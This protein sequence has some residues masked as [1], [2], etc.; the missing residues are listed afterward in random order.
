MKIAD[1]SVEDKS[2]GKLSALQS[3]AGSSKL[4]IKGSVVNCAP[5]SSKTEDLSVNFN[6]ISIKNLTFETSKRQ[7]NKSKSFTKASSR[8]ERSG[9]KS[10]SSNVIGYLNNFL[11]PKDLMNVSTLNRKFF[12]K[13]KNEHAYKLLIS[14]VNKKFTLEDLL[15]ND[16][17]LLA[18]YISRIN[19]SDTN[20]LNVEYVN[21]LVGFILN[22]CLKST[23]FRLKIQKNIMSRGFTYLSMADLSHFVQID[24]STNKIG[25]DG[26]EKLS[27]IIPF[28]EKLE[29]LNVSMN[30]ISSNG[31]NKMFESLKQAKSITELN[32]SGNSLRDLG[33]VVVASFLEVSSTIKIINLSYNAIE[34]KG[35][36]LL[37]EGILKNESLKSIN[38]ASNKFTGASLSHLLKLF[39]KNAIKARGFADKETLG[40]K[41]NFS[42][43]KRT[44]T[45]SEG[46]VGELEQGLSPKLKS[47][48][49]GA[50]MS[51]ASEFVKKLLFQSV[52]QANNSNTT[53]ITNK[54]LS[55]TKLNARQI[56]TLNLSSNKLD[57]ELMNDFLKEISNKELYNNTLNRFSIASTSLKSKNLPALSEVIENNHIKEVTLKGNN[58]SHNTLYIEVFSKA[59]QNSCFLTKLN[60]ENCHIGDEL[61]SSIFKLLSRTLIKEL[62]LNSNELTSES[63]AVLVDS[64][65]D[66]Q[67][68]SLFISSNNF[69][70]DGAQILNKAI[71]SNICS[72]LA[73][74]KISMIDMD[75][76]GVASFLPAIGNSNLVELDISVNNCTDDSG[77]EL[78][79][80]LVKEKNQIENLTVAGNNYTDEILDDLERTLQDKD[81]RLKKL[82]ISENNFTVNGLK[83]VLSACTSNSSLTQLN[84]S[85]KEGKAMSSMKLRKERNPELD[86]LLQE[87]QKQSH[88]KIII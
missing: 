51:T 67:L 43:I 34:D 71:S 14:I 26:I 72:S 69:G 87:Y 82:D 16:G 75:D 10:I 65:N 17:A 4:V 63:L 57:A 15:L 55:S 41:D 19:S 11:D 7:R 21:R 46:I 13:V 28:L 77:K 25:D 48:S 2:P 80:Y 22:Y 59:L 52:Y 58:L 60:L 44:N 53:N 8:K 38:I 78:F 9:M 40:K 62:N 20:E 33:M 68:D 70:N 3:S 23:K 56:E 18:L 39:K 73:S 27:K 74:L 84:I 50:K 5:N 42:L 61:A 49:Y 1:D 45:I 30:Q 24:L 6:Q 37:V 31:F 86:N 76:I 35:I 85:K 12:N 81:C 64:S 66:S 83:R 47:I 29:Y 32:V 36:E 54:K 88:L 79:S